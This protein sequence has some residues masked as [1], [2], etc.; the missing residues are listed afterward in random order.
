VKFA[1]LIS[2]AVSV[3]KVSI[4]LKMPILIHIKE[5]ILKLSKIRGGNLFLLFI[6]HY[7]VKGRNVATI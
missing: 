4:G 2:L 7:L 1:G 3:A 5:Y 6:V